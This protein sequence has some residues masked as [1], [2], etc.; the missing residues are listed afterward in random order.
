MYYRN[1]YDSPRVIRAALEDILSNVQE[2]FIGTL[3]TQDTMNA[4][5]ASIESMLHALYFKGS[6]LSRLIGIH[7]TSATSGPSPTFTIQFQGLNEDGKWL[8]TQLK[9]DEP[10]PPPAVLIPEKQEKVAPKTV[11]TRIVEL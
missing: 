3:L 8:L 6:H 7:I 10:L 2:V 5:E 9:I 11:F 4:A 1:P